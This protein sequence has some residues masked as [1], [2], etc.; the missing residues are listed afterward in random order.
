LLIN[1]VKLIKKGIAIKTI[2]KF[3]PANLRKSSVHVQRSVILFSILLLL[4]TLLLTHCANPVSPQGGAKDVNPPVVVACDPPNLATKFTKSSFRIDFNEFINLKNAATEIFISPPLKSAL[5]TRLKG[6]SLIVSIEDSLA[7]NTTYSIT[8]GNAIID[9][10]EGN[11][12]KG[13]NYVFSTGEFVD[14]LSLQ[15]NLLNAFDHKPQKD[16]FVELFMNNND[17]LPLDS[18]PL[19]V[20]PYYITK[21]DDQGNYLFRN[22]Q[23]GQFKLFALAD[24]NGDLI[25]NQPS[26]KIAFYDSLVNPYY[27]SVRKAD[28]SRMDSLQPEQKNSIPVKI[29]NADSLQKKDSIL[30]AD[31]IKQRFINY[32]SY[33]LYLFQE[34]DSVQRLLKSSFPMKGLVSLTFRFPVNNLQI[35]PLNFD[36]VAPWYIEEKSKQGDSVRLWITR[37]ETDSL[38]A[39]VIS[40]N[41]IIDTIRL[42]VIKKGISRKLTDQEKR[43]KLIIANSASNSGLNQYKNKLLITFSYPLVK[44]NFKRVLLISATDSIHPDI[45]FADSIKRTIVIHHKWEE[46][47]SYKILIP[48]SVFF[49]IQNF[50]HDSIIMEFRTRGEKDFGNLIVAMNMEKRPGQYLVQLWNE[51]ETTLYEEHIIT[52]SGNVSFAF[53]IPGKYRLKA[54]RDRNRNRKWDTGNYKLNIQPEEVIYLPKIVEIRA[55]WDVEEIWD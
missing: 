3:G 18:L 35:V 22:L 7:P 13:F 12:L 38:V 21:T 6:K 32:P 4:C 47:K 50:S 29:K 54:V 17:T 1:N 42:E 8:F 19:K 25:F 2:G 41:T 30:T 11:S 44:W 27:I 36:S 16:I 45:S 39:K 5:D 23:H 46:E 51:K 26:E 49:G 28:T 43:E 48:D 40:G 53:M 55:N 9:L 15:G 24:Q 52:S 33:S 37:P 34:T 31:S 20:A 14:T 10:T